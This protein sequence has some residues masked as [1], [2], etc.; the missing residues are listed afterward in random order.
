MNR[1]QDKIAIVT[2]A[3]GGIGL[4]A[5]K[6]FVAEGAR[7]VLVDLD[8]AALDAAVNTVG[9]EHASACVA[10][11]SD[12]AQA[13][14]YVS[15]AVERYGRLDVLFANAGIEGEV[16][17]IPEYDLDTYER[18]MAVNVRG[19]ML[20]LKFAM[21]VMAETGGGSIVITSSLAGLRGTQRLSA[22][23]ASK[24]AV[25]GLMK[26]AALE[27]ASKGIRV[28]TINPS[29]IAT[30]MIESLEQGYGAENLERVQSK[31]RAA[32][33]LKRYGEPREVANLA[34]FLASD[35]SSYCT[36]NTYSVDGGMCAA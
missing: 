36:G 12:P 15:A 4:E 22:Y 17:P 7:V 24:H 13:R 18:V 35:E 8:E 10:D 14:A 1:L 32:V 26:V 25:V 3:T 16:A 21:P 5:V 28:N 2:G 33:P 29:P 20:G 9:A 27:G 30:R 11:V 23:V 31:L 19:V 6:L 34:L